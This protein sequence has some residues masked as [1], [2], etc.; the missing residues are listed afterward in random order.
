MKKKASKKP[1]KIL[2]TPT[3]EEL[4]PS[5]AELKLYK[6]LDQWAKDSAGS[7]YMVGA[8]HGR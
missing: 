1:V 5:K 2:K 8:S 4:K 6:K 7:D 3:A